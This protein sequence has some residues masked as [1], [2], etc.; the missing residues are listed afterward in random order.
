MWKKSII[1]LTLVMLIP[2][3]LPIFAEVSQIQLDKNSYFKGDSINIKGT[4]D[5]DASGLVTIVLRDPENKFILLSQSKIQ[6]DNSFEHDIKINEKFQVPGTYNATAFIL[7]ITAAK[8]YS[9]EF[10]NIILNKNKNSKEI[11]M[12]I[13]E[14]VLNEPK[15][16]NVLLESNTIEIEDQVIEE[17]LDQ[18]TKKIE[19]SQTQVVDFVD[20]TKKPEYYLDRYYSE[21]VYR[22]WFDR[23]YPN[24]TIEQAVGYSTPP[25]IENK[26]IHTNLGSEI[27]PEAEATLMESQNFDA[28]YYNESTQVGLAITGLTVLFGGVY[29]VKRRIDNNNKPVVLNKDLL[30]R[31]LFTS[32]NDQNLLSIIKSRLA[33]GEIAIEEYEEL[34][35]KLKKDQI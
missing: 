25:Q 15:I 22:S 24:L 35:Q 10:D 30:K 20:K 19:E 14:P 9:F 1:L 21:P 17:I 7:N 8:T 11:L 29:V 18:E 34:R 3:I 23:N 6:S 2:G 26:F 5:D 31:K 27:I 13:P 16:T 32:K 33:K 28:Y 4:V 12:K